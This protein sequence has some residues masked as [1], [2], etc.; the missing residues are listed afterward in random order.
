[1]AAAATTEPAGSP[2]PPNAGSEEFGERERE[3]ASGKEIGR[4]RDR[5]RRRPIAP[6]SGSHRA[7]PHAPLASGECT[8]APAGL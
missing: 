8:V 6:T 4:G 2:L 1:V 7:L 5:R 3:G